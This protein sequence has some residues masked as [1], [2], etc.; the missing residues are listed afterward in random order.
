MTW[1]Q[2]I[3]SQYHHTLA[4][5]RHALDQYDTPYLR[6]AIPYRT[7][8]CYL[9]TAIA[10]LGTTIV[11]DLSTAH[12]GAE[13]GRLPQAEHLAREPCA[14]PHTRQQCLQKWQHRLHK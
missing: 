12:S 14:T 6:T 10:H 3:L 2:Q 8:I 5:Y 13:V 4:S 9:S 11:R 7:V 1:Y